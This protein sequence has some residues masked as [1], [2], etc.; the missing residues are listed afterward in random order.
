MSHS[1]PSADSAWI[2]SRS[3]RS[4]ARIRSRRLHDIV[5]PGT[6]GL[7]GEIRKRWRRSFPEGSEGREESTVGPEVDGWAQGGCRVDPWQAQSGARVSFGWILGGSRKCFEVHL[8]TTCR[9][10]KSEGPVFER[11]EPPTQKTFIF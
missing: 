4:P 5:Q 9:R 11:G 1:R 8:T 6:P 2:R 7:I 3:F 10:F